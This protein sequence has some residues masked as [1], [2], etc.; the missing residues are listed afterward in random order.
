MFHLEQN[1]IEDDRRTNIQDK[2]RSDD[3]CQSQLGN[4]L[5]DAMKAFAI[6]VV[7]KASGERANGDAWLREYQRVIVKLTRISPDIQLTV[8]LI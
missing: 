8:D 7:F 2:S 4:K 6:T 3:Q 5:N 1:G